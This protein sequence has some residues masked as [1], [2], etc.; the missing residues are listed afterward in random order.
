MVQRYIVIS[1]LKSDTVSDVSLRGGALE[2]VQKYM[3][4]AC[5]KA[6]RVSD[7]S[8]RGA[9][10]EVAGLN[11]SRGRDLPHVAKLSLRV[12]AARVHHSAYAGYIARA[13]QAQ[14][15]PV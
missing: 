11:L 9:L 7:L 14:P 6:T 3:A 5:L 15:L 8:L 1:G 4:I 2:E 12:N 13:S 10:D